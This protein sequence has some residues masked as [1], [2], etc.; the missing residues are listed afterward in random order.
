MNRDYKQ[1]PGYY[2]VG[3]YSS[4]LMLE[5]ALK[6]VKGKIEDKQAFMAALRKVQL[7]NDP[8]GKIS[9]D[10]LGNPIMDIYIRKVERKNGKLVNAVIK[11]YPQVSQFWTYKQADFLAAP[12]YSRDYP[13]AKNLEK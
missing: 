7:T 4:A 8:R 1:D 9:L 10:A 13:P 12:V 2:S 5:Q 3:A 6:D 11:T